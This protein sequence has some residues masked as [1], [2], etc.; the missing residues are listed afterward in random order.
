MSP[1]NQWIHVYGMCH[2]MRIDYCKSWEFAR[3]MYNLR[4]ITLNIIKSHFIISSHRFSIHHLQVC[5]HIAY[6]CART[7]DCQCTCSH[8]FIYISPCT[9]NFI[10]NRAIHVFKHNMCLHFHVYVYMVLHGQLLVQVF[11]YEYTGASCT[12]PTWHVLEPKC[13]NP[14]N[15]GDAKLDTALEFLRGLLISILVL[16]SSKPQND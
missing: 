9:R 4:N 2:I 11:V 8:V 14:I 16:W 1:M 7:G 5:T 15:F 3:H 10:V 12:V 6:A 13:C